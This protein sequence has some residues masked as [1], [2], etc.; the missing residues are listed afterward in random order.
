MITATCRTCH[1]DWTIETLPPPMPTATLVKY[2]PRLEAPCGHGSFRGRL[3]PDALL[4]LSAIHGSYR[5]QESDFTWRWYDQQYDAR[6]KEWWRYHDNVPAPDVEPWDPPSLV[7]R[8]DCGANITARC[9]KLGCGGGESGTH[10][11]D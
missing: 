2:Q 5:W 7:M 6:E 4:K 3:A 11:G 10:S 8:C 9:V 1:Q